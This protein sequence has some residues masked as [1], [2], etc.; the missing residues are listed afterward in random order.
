[1][2][3][4]VITCVVDR[5]GTRVGRIFWFKRVH[6]VMHIEAPFD[7]ATSERLK[8]ENGLLLRIYRAAFAHDPTSH[9]T[10]LARSNLIALRHTVR[11]VYGQRAAVDVTDALGFISVSACAAE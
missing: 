4:A 7:S 6:W 9:A 8:K 1:M 5:E 2:V 3:F 10:E 11:Q